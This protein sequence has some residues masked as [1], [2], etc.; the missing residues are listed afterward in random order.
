MA[1]SEA[2]LP[3]IAS[4][5]RAEPIPVLL[6]VRELDQGG[7]ERDVAKIALHLDRT[8]FAPRVAAY[9]AHGLRYEELMSAGIPIL[10][11]PLR[12]LASRDT[13]RLGFILWRYIRANGIKIVHA[14][15]SS[16][17]I[18]LAVAQMAR[19]PVVIGS[20]LSYRNILDPNTRTLLRLADRYSDAIFVN[21]EAIRR[22]MVEDEHVPAGKVELCY[23]GVVTH[24]FFPNHRETSETSRAESL[25][26]GTVCVLRPEKNLSLLQEAFARVKSIRSGLKLVIVG[27]GPSLATL[28]EHADRL[29]ISQ[30]TV[31]VPATRDVA[32]WLRAMDIF[33]LP[34]YSEAFSN[35]L[36]EAM[37]CGCAVI[38]SRVGGT[39]ELVGISEDRGLLF[40]SCSVEQLASKLARLITND[41]Q[42]RSLGAKA[43]KF[44]STHLTVELA[45][46]TTANIYDK[47]LAGVPPVTQYNLGAPFYRR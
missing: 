42:R 11:L 30:S 19:V 4:P 6:L 34:S 26:I 14:Y 38:G 12:K 47:L 44:A 2:E 35:S 16:G 20:Q 7:V 15:D 39:P 28:K 43:A 46:E 27:S 24:E 5:H 41:E 33:V 3:G 23:N 29:E 13:L 36:L 45:A 37:A 1:A 40:Q 17:I 10:N 8:R 9:Y 32:T 22:Y 18:G 31:F 25:I 21:C